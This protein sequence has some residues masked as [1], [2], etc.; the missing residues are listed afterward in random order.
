MINLQDFDT[1][2]RP[3]DDFYHYAI[4]GWLK[5][6][7]IP[8]DESYWGS[9]TILRLENNK[10]LKGLLEDLQQRNTSELPNNFQ[11]LKLYFESAIDA[12]KVENSGISGIQPALKKIQSVRAH[13][14]LPE[15]LGWMHQRD[16][17][18]FWKLVFDLDDKN[19]EKYALRL[20]QAGLG[21]P[22]REYYLKT[23]ERM[24]L[25]QAGYKTFIRTNLGLLKN[26]SPTETVKLTE[27]IYNLEQQIAE[28]S[29]SAVECRDV[30]ALY[31]PHSVKELAEKST[32]D[33]RKYFQT[34]GLGHD[35]III[36]S[37]PNFFERIYKIIEATDIEL[38]KEYLS[39][40]LLIATSST[41]TQEF[42]Q[43]R[44]AF[45]GKII[46][47][48]EKMLPRWRR[49]LQNMN[50]YLEEPLGEIY[51]TKYFSK[52]AKAAVEEMAENIFTAFKNRLEKL[53]WMGEETKKAAFLKLSSFKRKLGY[54]EKF[55]D[56]S[57]LTLGE[58]YT[59]N[60]L[61]AANFDFQYK[62][63][64]LAQPVDKA[65]WHCGAH[66][67]NAFYWPNYNDISFP[68]G[69][70]QFPFFD[71]SSDMAENYG[72]IGEVI[73][74]EL[75]HGFDDTGSKFDEKGNLKQWWTEEDRRHFDELGEKLIAQYNTCQ[76]AENLYVN[77]KLTN[78]ENIAD[79]GGITIAFE[80]YQLH[81]AHTGKREDI[82]GLTPEQRL[83]LAF[84]REYG[85]NMRPEVELMLATTDT[86]S[87]NN[88]RVNVPL[89]NLDAFYQAFDVKEGDKMYKKPEDRIKIW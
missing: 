45:Y 61:A 28:A 83:F 68:A 53:Q 9:F 47:G 54:P 42:V 16:I 80:A 24:A 6:N 63:N 86:H 73:G 4:G 59:E 21:M 39:V 82:N 62:I 8:E 1:S 84:V 77:G 78:G 32:F 5:S 11:K 31:N 70:L 35:N 74:H 33:L 49:V 27:D 23:D 2:I 72:A 85:H 46:T 36:E 30:D 15:I 71:L 7:P 88:F 41:L 26:S 60:F 20:W 29:W 34:M 76:I 55:R 12:E 13:E 75:T 48:T 69:I 79:L 64:K 14:D 58:N 44:F 57:T 22:D 25:A 51:V 67:V 87:P 89:S 66:I 38:I 43:A 37:Q 18:P 56:F 19:S 52:E 17:T 81:L 10:R 50:L 40:H 65:E 3:Q